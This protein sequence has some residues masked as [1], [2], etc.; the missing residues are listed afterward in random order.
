MNRATHRAL[1]RRGT[2]GRAPAF[3]AGAAGA[4]VLLSVLC[5][6]TVADPGEAFER[7]VPGTDPLFPPDAWS[8]PVAARAAPDDPRLDYDAL[9]YDLFFEPD[10]DAKTL[11][12]ETIMTLETRGSGLQSIVLDLGAAMEVARAWFDSAGVDVDVAATR[13]GDRVT[14]PLSRAVADEETLRIGVAYQ[15]EPDGS[16]QFTHSFFLDRTEETGTVPMA[17][18]LSEP[19]GAHRWWACKNLVD[20]KATV[21]IT[22]TVP[23]GMIGVANGNPAER[24]DTPSGKTVFTWTSRYPTSPYLVAIAVTDYAQWS[25]TYRT[26]DGDSLDLV[27]YAYPEDEADARQDWSITG[28]AM[29][30]FEDLFGAY[31]FR[32]LGR[33]KYG[34]VEFH[35]GGALEHQTITSVGRGFVRGDNASDWVVAHELGHQWFGDAVGLSEWKHIWTKEG[36]ATYCEALYLEKRVLARGG[37][38]A[39]ARSAL[40]EHMRRRFSPAIHDT[41]LMSDPANLYHPTSVYERGAWICHMLRRIMGDE[42]FFEAMRNYVDAWLYG[43]AGPDEFFTEMEQSHGAD[44]R[45]FSD[46]WVYRMGRPH[47]GLEW[48]SRPLG[49]GT[50]EVSLHL[51]QAQDG[52]VYRFPLDVDLRDGATVERR[53]IWMERRWQD[54][55]LESPFQPADL[56]LD[57][58]GWLLNGGASDQF[59]EGFFELDTGPDGVELRVPAP[60]PLAGGGHAAIRYRVPSPG[61]ARLDLHDVTGRRVATLFSKPMAG[62]WQTFDW[63]GLVE[64]ERLASGAYV[65]RLEHP[66]GTSSRKLIILR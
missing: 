16:L 51:E 66:A 8:R 24:W 41:Q 52:G 64:G 61:T 32:R 28:E 1:S 5:P 26:S 22:L 38:A 23:Q 9:H 58:D 53:E 4:L 20:D 33:E 19:D 17:A 47:V 10:F 31:P 2:G 27:F 50:W 13:D 55:V 36:L 21:T 12:G 44:L 37:T 43:N 11:Y 6:P 63:N 34:M 42:A 60:H 39:Q 35:W 18:S 62:G 25:E 7:S 65:I 3:G 45:W 59:A 15:G 56:V 54:F 57:P 29:R 49:D 30:I 48:S 14:I 46:Q 40:R